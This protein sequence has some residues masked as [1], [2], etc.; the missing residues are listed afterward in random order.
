MR[1]PLT[2]RSHCGAR[3]EPSHIQR[4]LGWLPALR[5]PAL[6]QLSHTQGQPAL[7]ISSHLDDV[8]KV[9]VLGA[10]RGSQVTLQRA[11]P[12]CCAD[13]AQRLALRGRGEEMCEVAGTQ[14]A[15][16]RLC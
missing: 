3:G 16:W 14:A 7:A 15:V 6:H 12:S 1:S 9:A 10:Q 8:E 11:A 4:Y 2:R 5:L 13:Q